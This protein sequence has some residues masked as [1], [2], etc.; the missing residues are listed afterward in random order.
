ML[1]PGRCVEYSFVYEQRS[2]GGVYAGLK[3]E[4]ERIPKAARAAPKKF[5]LESPSGVGRGQVPDV[6]EVAAGGLAGKT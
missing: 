2:V 6:E 1:S 3:K 5:K 4:W